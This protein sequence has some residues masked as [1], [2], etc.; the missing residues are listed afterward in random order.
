MTTCDHCELTVPCSTCFHCEY[1]YCDVCLHTPFDDDDVPMSLFSKWYHSHE[2]AFKKL[3]PDSGTTYAELKA[4]DAEDDRITRT[5]HVYDQAAKKYTQWTGLYE[6]SYNE[7][8]NKEKE[9]RKAKNARRKQPKKDALDKQPD[10]VKALL[11]SEDEEEEEE[12]V[13]VEK[14]PTPPTRMMPPKTPPPSTPAPTTTTTTT[15]PSTPPMATMPGWSPMMYTTP[16]GTVSATP[17][18]PKKP[19]KARVKR[20]EF[21]AKTVSYIH[22]LQLMPEKVGL[23]LLHMI[24]ASLMQANDT[25]EEQMVKSI[26]QSL[27]NVPAFILEEE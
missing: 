24:Q 20:Q 6:A 3:Y 4:E 21:V 9:E 26:E 25:N 12:M 22:E 7:D 14:K 5:D 15:I 18:A 1:H 13:V 23:E 27:E 16:N 19:R 11:Q 2:I 17:P 10:L 8:Y